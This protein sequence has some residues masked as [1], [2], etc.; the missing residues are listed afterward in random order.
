MRAWDNP[1]GLSEESNGLGLK[2]TATSLSLAGVPLLRITVAGLTPRPAAEVSVLMRAAYNRDFDA[3]ALSAGLR[4]VADALNKGDLG[5]AMVGA[6]RLR[7]AELDPGDAQHLANAEQTL[8]KYDVNELRDYRGWWTDG[9]D[10]TNGSDIT[11][12]PVPI[13]TPPVPANGNVRSQACL[14]AG[15]QCVSN[16]LK[17]TTRTKDSQRQY[18]S[19]CQKAEDTCLLVLNISQRTPEQEFRILFPDQTVVGIQD[20]I[21]SLIYINGMRLDAPWS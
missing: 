16:A 5:R 17:D 12:K 10:D 9:S 20:G 1:F 3:R 21:S 13:A 19:A 4:V 2:C 8:T 6:I 11:M 18:F 14:N 15:R 7:L